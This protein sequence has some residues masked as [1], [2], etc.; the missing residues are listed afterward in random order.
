[1]LAAIHALQRS[2]VTLPVIAVPLMLLSRTCACSCSRPLSVS[3][4]LTP[5]FW[6]PPAS[7]CHP[8]QASALITATATSD[9]ATLQRAAHC[10]AFGRATR[11]GVRREWKMGDGLGVGGPRG[12]GW[13][14][15]IVL[16]CERVKPHVPNSLAW[17]CASSMPRA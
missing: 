7:L 9:Q 8:R 10:H 15:A 17:K 14:W 13:G 1:M 3:R 16:L 12:S 4:P 11:P 6:V 2:I 5:P